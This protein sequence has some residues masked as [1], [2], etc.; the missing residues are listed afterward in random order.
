MNGDL[1]LRNIFSVVFRVGIGMLSIMDYT[2]LAKPMVKDFIN[3]YIIIN[4]IV[5]NMVYFSSYSLSLIMKKSD[6][7]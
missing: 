1:I 3:T 6:S 2:T 7:Y 4:A 5:I